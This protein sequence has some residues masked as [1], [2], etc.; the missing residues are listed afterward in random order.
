MSPARIFYR[1]LKDCLAKGQSAP[2][3]A[4]LK[5]F[6]LLIGAWA[7]V[8]FLKMLHEPN[9]FSDSERRRV[10]GESSKLDQW[11]LAVELG[12]RRRYHLPKAKLSAKVLSRTAYH[13][14]QDIHDLIDNDLRPIIEIRNKLAHGQWSRT[15]NGDLSEISKQMMSLLNSENA[16]SANFKMKIIEVLSRIVNDLLVGAKAFERDFDVHYGL[17]EQ[18]RMNLRTR[19]FNDWEDSLKSKYQRGRGKQKA[20]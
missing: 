4:L 12:F 9:A 10:L 3:A 8:R 17:L 19:R 7:E 13:R 14:L 20:G 1:E 18:T 11:K 5:T 16:L 6:I 2:A 15:F